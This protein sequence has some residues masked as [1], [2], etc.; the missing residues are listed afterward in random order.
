MLKQLQ[1]IMT[2]IF[3]IGAISSATAAI[4]LEK[5][6][7]HQS[8]ITPK[9]VFAQQK[10]SGFTIADYEKLT[11]KRLGFFDKMK[12]K[13]AQKYAQKAKNQEGSDKKILS[14]LAMLLGIGGLL[15]FLFLPLLGGLMSIAGLVLGIRALKKENSKVM[16]ILGIVFGGLTLVV[17]LAV[18]IFAASFSFV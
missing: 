4:E 16:A 6:S 8:S 13:L 9:E 14:L 18:I 17:L 12:L 11:G 10:A 5:G 3:S 1:F 7:T 15:S 2:L